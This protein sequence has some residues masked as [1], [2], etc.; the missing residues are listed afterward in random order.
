MNKYMAYEKRR[1]STPQVL[2]LNSFMSYLNFFIVQ[3]ITINK[4][5]FQNIIFVGTGAVKHQ[6]IT[7]KG[8]RIIFVDVTAEPYLRLHP[9]N[10]VPYGTATA[11]ATVP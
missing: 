11:M 10:P 2:S 1:D 8:N 6:S 7:D 5:T 9:F 4:P 3:C